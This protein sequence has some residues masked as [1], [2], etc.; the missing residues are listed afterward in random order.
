MPISHHSVQGL[1]YTIQKSCSDGESS[2]P[3]DERNI[4]IL[5]IHFCILKYNFHWGYITFVFK[6]QHVYYFCTII[7]VKSSN[8]I[9]E[10]NFKTI[11]KFRIKNQPH[12]FDPFET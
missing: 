5:N 6:I 8:K 4:G 9:T 12:L 7:D 11:Q 3:Q 1:S 2:G 10:K